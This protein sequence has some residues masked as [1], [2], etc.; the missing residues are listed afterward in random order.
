MI[1]DPTFSLSDETPDASFKPTFA[2]EERA[3]KEEVTRAFGAAA[4]EDGDDEGMDG[5]LVKRSKTKDEQQREKEDYEKF[6]K[7]NAGDRAVEDALEA[8]EK[9]LRE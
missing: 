6:L 4:S 8:E 5:L 2:Q 1:A 9:F 7:E 3:L